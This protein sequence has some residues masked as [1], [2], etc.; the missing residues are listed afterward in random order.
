MEFVTRLLKVLSSLPELSKIR[1]SLSLIEED[2]EEDE[3][4]EL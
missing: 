1:I 2:A 3:V 4:V